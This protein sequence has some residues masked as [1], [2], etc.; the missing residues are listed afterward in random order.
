MLDQLWF[1]AR[2]ML[3]LQVERSSNALQRRSVE[4]G[5][6]IFG[7]PWHWARLHCRVN[8][9]Y[10]SRNMSNLMHC[11]A[12]CTPPLLCTESFYYTQAWIGGPEVVS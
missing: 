12:G 5:V 3:A 6:K 10:W 2:L 1:M 4:S 8:K 7:Q 9:I 11:Q